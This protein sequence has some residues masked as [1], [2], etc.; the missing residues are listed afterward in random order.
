MK[1]NHAEFS[2]IFS[3]NDCVLTT[4][5]EYSEEYERFIKADKSLNPVLILYKFKMTNNKW[6]ISTVCLMSPKQKDIE[7]MFKD[8]KII[9][10]INSDMQI[11]EYKIKRA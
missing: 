2:N 5:K 11:T 8:D 4:L 3:F 9:C 6:L 7:E 1:L 10:I